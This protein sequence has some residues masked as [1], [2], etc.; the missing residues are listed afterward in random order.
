MNDYEMIVIYFNTPLLPYQERLVHFF[1]AYENQVDYKMELG[2]QVINFTGYLFPIFPYKSIGDVRALFVDPEDSVEVEFEKVGEMGIDTGSGI[3]YDIIRDSSIDFIDPYLANIAADH[4][5]ITIT[6]EDNEEDPTGIF[7][8]MELKEI[9]REIIISAW[10]IIKVKEELLIQNDGVVDIE[11]FFLRVP[12]DGK[13][14]KVY[15][16]LGQLSGVTI[17]EY[18]ADG[19]YTLIANEYSDSEGSY[20]SSTTYENGNILRIEFEDSNNLS[21]YINYTYDENGNLVKEEY[22]SSKG[23]YYTTTYIYEGY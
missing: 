1:H 6:F 11:Y 19:N 4:K 7:T 12:E 9:F 10:G 13:S 16:E 15:D 18:D 22:K 17:F 20:K 5:E 21:Y 14:I 23:D 2:E 8:K 3:L